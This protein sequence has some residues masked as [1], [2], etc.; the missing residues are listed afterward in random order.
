MSL[1]Q[2]PRASYPVYFILASSLILATL[3]C[4]LQ[5]GGPEPPSPPV[6]IPP[7]ASTLLERA[8][9]SALDAAGQT[10]EIKLSVSES[11]LN[12]LLDEKLQA[13][14]SPFILQPQV[15]LRQGQIQVYGVSTQGL[16]QARVFV[17]IRPFIDP[18]GQLEIEIPSAEFGSLPAP[19]ALKD[20]LSK[21]FTDLFDQA[22]EPVAAGVRVTSIDITDGQM[23]IVATLR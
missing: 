4:Q 23:A 15:Y 14:G 17:A 12:G 16:V 6:E 22:I 10:G 5:L 20:A 18:D 7:D 2:P 21:S 11:Q 13:E 1:V 9:T 19:A 8:W 3:A